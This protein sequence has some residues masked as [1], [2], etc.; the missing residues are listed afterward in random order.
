VIG[1]LGLHVLLLGWGAA[2][3]TPSIDEVGFLAAGISHWTCGSFDL[4]RV[5]PPLV[6]MLGT[7]PAREDAD[8]V[9]Q[10]ARH[11]QVGAQDAHQ[12]A[13]AGVR[14]QEV[15]PVHPGAPRQR[16]MVAQA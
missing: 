7:L 10:L 4:Y 11:G 8:R 9:P 13:I 12:T 15:Q 14:T 1:L 6:R 2:R 5:N 3:H 16:G